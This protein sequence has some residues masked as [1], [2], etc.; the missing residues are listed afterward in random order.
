MPLPFEISI[1][2]RFFHRIASWIEVRILKG[3]YSIDGIINSFLSQEKSGWTTA[4]RQYYNLV[5]N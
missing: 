5:S 4:Q 3:K 1:F 2:E